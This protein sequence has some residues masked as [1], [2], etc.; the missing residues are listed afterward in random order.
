MKKLLLYIFLVSVFCGKSHADQVLL[1]SMNTHV[2]YSDNETWE[3]LEKRK[4]T[5]TIKS[6]SIKIFS[7]NM[8]QEEK[9]MITSQNKLYTN[10]MKD[11]SDSESGAW[12]KYFTFN[13]KTNEIK[14]A[15]TNE[16]GETYHIGKCRGN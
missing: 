16:Y 2:K 6:R 10:A 13:N 5:V 9:L 7:H 14:Y 15:S 12:L 3:N 4:W 1:C 8:G 11:D